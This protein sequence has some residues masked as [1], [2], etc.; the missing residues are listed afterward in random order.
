MSPARA[1]RPLPALAVAAALCGCGSGGNFTYRQYGNVMG[2]AFRSMFSH[3]EVPRQAAASI[4]Y[5]SLG[6][7]LNG[8]DEFMLVLATSNEQ[9]EIWTASSHVVFQTRQG[10]VTRTVGL[11]SDLGALLPQQGLALAP[12]SAAL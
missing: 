1:L 7:R 12:P 11:P 10:R 6:Y 2:Q 5:A 4:P 9:G 3:A 8:K